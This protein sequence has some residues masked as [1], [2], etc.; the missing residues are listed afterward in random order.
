MAEST[1]V[2]EFGA[3][4][5][6]IRRI[7]ADRPWVW[8]GRGWE[9][10]RRAAPVSLLW[11]FQFAI[12]GLGL[13]WL[14]HTNRWYNFL[15][16]LIAGFMLL[17]PILVVG[18]YKV[19]KELEAGNKVTSSTPFSAWSDN[20]GQIG[21]M[22]FILGLFFLAWIR[23]ATLLFAIFFGERPPVAYGE[24]TPDLRAFFEQFILSAE[25]VPFLVVGT[26]VGAVLAF[27][28]FSIAAVSV[29]MLLDKKEANVFEAVATSF[30]AVSVNF[31]PMV[32]WAVLIALF[33]AA[34]LA[35][36]FIGLTVTLPLIAH[37]SWHAY[38]DLVGYPEKTE[39]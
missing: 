4:S 13:V 35:L 12:V 2:A 28:V 18:L 25:N 7:G 19:S 5:P 20:A 17:A 29:P 27:V 39:T 23:F 14:L 22:G 8:L 32:L 1:E 33:T 21:L 15:F 34:G 16:P 3:T 24:G 31:W 37:A 26:A 10:L 11:G 9:D 36:A 30:R 6:R 38:R